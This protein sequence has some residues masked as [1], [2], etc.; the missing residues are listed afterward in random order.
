MPPEAADALQ[1]AEKMRNQMAGT[2]APAT[3]TGAKP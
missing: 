3:A 1:K 2:L